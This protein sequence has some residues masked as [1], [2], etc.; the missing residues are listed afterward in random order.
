MKSL[1]SAVVA[2]AGSEVIEDSMSLIFSAEVDVCCDKAMRRPV[3]EQWDYCCRP[4]V[5]QL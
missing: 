4:V 2:E 1:A 5:D 3:V